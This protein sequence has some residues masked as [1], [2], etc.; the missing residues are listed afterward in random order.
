M[1]QISVIGL[2]PTVDEHSIKVEGTSSAIISDI[3]V[4]LLENQEIFQEIYPDSDKDDSDASED[5]T[6]QNASTKDSEDEAL[7]PAQTELKAVREKIVTVLDDVKRADEV[8]SSA[9]KRL[10][11]LEEYGKK[12]EPKSGSDVGDIVD[13]YTEQ[14]GKTFQ[15][16]IDG[17]IRQRELHAEVTRLRKKENKLKAQILKEDNKRRKAAAKIQEAK[18]K[19]D[20]IA[21][22][23]LQ[24]KAAEKARIRREKEK[25]WPRSCYTVRITLDATHYTP[26]SSRR[27]SVASVTDLVK[28]VVEDPTDP[29]SPDPETP[30]PACDISLSYVTSAAFWSPSYDLQLNTTANTGTLFFDAQL[31]NNTSEAW[32]DC[33]I[34]LST[35]QAVFSGLQDEI[36]KLVPWR[37]KLAGRFGGGYHG[38]GDITSSVQEMEQRR[39]YQNVSTVASK[40]KHGAD[41][42]GLQERPFMVQVSQ[43]KQAWACHPTTA[44]ES[45]DRN[46]ADQRVQVNM[47]DRMKSKSDSITPSLSGGLFGQR[48]AASQAFGAP[49]VRPQAAQMMQMQ[50]QGGGLFGS[51]ANPPPP[52]AASGPQLF[53]AL[54]S[55]TLAEVDED[56]PPVAEEVTLR[57]PEPSLDFQESAM[58]ETGL[59]TTYDLPG[60]KTLAPS[61]NAS[62]QRV[63]RILFSGVAF[64]HTVVAKYRPAAFLKA[65][66]RNASKMSLLRGPVGLT[67]DGTFM[68]RSSLPRCSS[69]DSFTMSLGVDPTIRVSYPKP[70]V[71][72]SSSGVFSKE[73]ST[74]YRRSI[75]ITNTR[76]A[77]SSSSPSSSSNGGSG[78]AKP[79][80]LVVLDQVPVSEDDKLRVDIAHPGGLREGGAGVSTG[81]LEGTSSKDGRDWGKATATLKKGGEVSWD[82]ELNAGRGVKLDLEYEVS[83][84]AGDV[85]VQSTDSSRW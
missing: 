12:F 5:E 10:S 62:K 7:T 46:F 78:G 9:E 38:N 3:S 66:L 49:A 48:A 19:K 77:S 41:L 29:A 83:L 34:I 58:E 42:I 25:F 47:L 64:S 27:S 24:K 43:P 15:D 13:V 1:N 36:P 73:N 40:D 31:T 84:P 68:G 67:L 74:A 6:G 51:S 20:Q 61:T 69:G 26:I 75:A 82:V 33:K 63:A 70:D 2:T 81:V 45:C 22:A 14:R 55:S 79:V 8:V 39:K 60:T 44:L 28:P 52:P 65:K 80:R 37:I 56:A 32:K 21:N 53:G 16:H 30:Y 71:K 23:R 57:E 59:T 54:K 18:R 72:R 17:T 76:G 35:S 50:Q 4:E 11:L 85:A